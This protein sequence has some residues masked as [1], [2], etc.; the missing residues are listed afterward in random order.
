MRPTLDLLR[1]MDLGIDFVEP[2]VGQAAKQATGTLFPDAAKAQID[3]ADATFFGSTSG[4]STPVLF[5]L[6]WGK[7]TYANLRPCVYTPGFNSPLAQPAGIDFAI[8]RENLEDLYLGLEGDT[9]DLAG[10]N[11]YSRHARA[12]LGDLG[13]GKYAI[14]AITEKGSE[15]VIRYAFELARQRDKQRKVTVTCKY[16]MLAVADG[17]FLEIGKAVA[18]EYSDIEFEHF[19]I[20]DF[21]CRMIANPHALDVVVMPNLYGDIM[22]DGAAGLIGG[23]GLAPSGCYGEDYAYFESAHG[24]APDIA[25]QNVINPTA[26]LLSATMLLDYVDRGQAAT[27]LRHAVTTVYKDKSNLTTDQGGSAGTSDFFLALNNA[28]E[29]G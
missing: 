13:P 11:L 27:R 4:D 6:R 10:L 25:G 14:K 18:S 26:T 29:T 7:Q 19:I 24:T 23:L 16:N 15:R 9:E 17:L 1:A 5:Y 12:N 28:L 2:V 21:L 8:V 22:S 3:A 20:D